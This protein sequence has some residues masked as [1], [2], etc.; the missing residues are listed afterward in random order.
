[1]SRSMAIIIWRTFPSRQITG[2]PTYY[3]GYIGRERIEQ[4]CCAR[5]YHRGQG[6]ADRCAARAATR[7][8]KEG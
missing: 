7:L 8:A 5:G 6:V 1:M 2:R 4:H 3:Y